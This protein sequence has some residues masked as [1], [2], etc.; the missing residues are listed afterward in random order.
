[1]N[2]QKPTSE[3]LENGLKTFLDNFVK[4]Y[5]DGKISDLYDSFSAD[6]KNQISLDEF[7][8]AMKNYKERFGGITDWKYLYS[9][10]LGNRGGIDGFNIYFHTDLQSDY[11]I[12]KEGFLKLLMLHDG[13][14]I[15]YFGGEWMLSK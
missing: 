8:K 11:L 3:Y 2:I 4:Y 9:V 1:M 5:N 10:Y 7:S 12:F 6:Y 15:K 14:E 13:N